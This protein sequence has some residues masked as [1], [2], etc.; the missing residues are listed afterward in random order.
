MCSFESQL[1]L[2][3]DGAFV[4]GG[5]R[6]STVY[7]RNWC[8]N[9]G[10]SAL[11]WDGYYQ[12]NVTGGLMLENVAWN[13][14]ALTI[15]GDRHNVTRNSVFGGADTTATSAIRDRPKYQDHTFS[16]DN[17]SIPSASVGVGRPYVNCNPCA[18]LGEWDVRPGVTARPQP[19]GTDAPFPPEPGGGR[20]GGLR[21]ALLVVLT[22][23]FL[24]STLLL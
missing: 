4:E 13:T 21:T 7:V 9:T 5:G 2:Q 19:P 18:M 1:A 15:K 24:T 10:K 6:P 16:L 3:D 11:R 23:V 12:D 22:S 17:L 8:T 14:S 20:L